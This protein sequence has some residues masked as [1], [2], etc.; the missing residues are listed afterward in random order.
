MSRK[1]RKLIW[2]VPLV[3][4]FAVVGALAAFGALGLGG[5]F[6]PMSCDN[7][8]QNLKVKAADGNA[9]RTN[10]VLTWEAPPAGSR[11]VPAIDVSETTRSSR[12][13]RR[14]PAGTAPTTHLPHA[15][16]SMKTTERERLGAVL[17]GL[18]G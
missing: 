16:R 12:S 5:V 4:V 13:L 7:S 1:T 8:P 9:G 2:S 17:P 6:A 10:L 14:G 15:A 18:C 11:Y 3:A